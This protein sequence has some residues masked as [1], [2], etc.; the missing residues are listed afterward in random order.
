[1][2]AIN[3]AA[4]A[5]VIKKKYPQT[6]IWLLLISV[7]LMELVWVVLNFLGIE[8]SSTESSV[9]SVLDVHLTYMPYSHSIFSTIIV[10]LI[11]WLVIDRYLHRPKMALAVATGIASHLVL[12]MLTH[13][14]DIAVAPFLELE[15][16][17]LGVYSVPIAAFL[18]E[19]FYGIFCWWIYKGSSL[20]LASIVAFNL[21]NFSFFSTAISGPEVF[22]ANQPLLLTSVVLIQIVLTL[23]LVGSLSQK[24]AGKKSISAVSTS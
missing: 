7:Q 3:H 8:Y 19:T 1:M 17:G 10:A 16:I 5:L 24:K 22:L 18:V 23:V 9:S 15:K 13:T 12:D 2:F 20:L 6:P 21:A 14:Q 4:T 11:A